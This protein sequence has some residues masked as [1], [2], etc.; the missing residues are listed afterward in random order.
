MVPDFVVHGY[1]GRLDRR[2][3]YAHGLGTTD[4]NLCHSTSA[5]SD[6]GIRRHYD[7]RVELYIVH[8]TVFLW[9]GNMIFLESVSKRPWYDV[10]RA[11]Q[12]GQIVIRQVCDDQTR[13]RCGHRPP[14]GNIAAR[15]YAM[16]AT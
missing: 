16:E 8:S 9:I 2:N 5:C 6:I 3:F 15:R 7:I 4:S 13:Q 14:D 11:G 12:P 10:V 1:E